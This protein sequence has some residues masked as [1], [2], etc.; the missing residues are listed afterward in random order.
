MK[1]KSDHVISL[2]QSFNGWAILPG[3]VPV[4]N[5]P[6]GLE[7]KVVQVCLGLTEGVAYLH[8]YCV[9]HRDIKPDKSSILM[10]SSLLKSNA[11]SPYR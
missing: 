5:W 10:S 3:M 2:I 6:E 11:T 9:A 8:K 1:L 7:S 4:E